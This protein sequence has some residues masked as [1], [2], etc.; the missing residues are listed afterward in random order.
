[1]K[2]RRLLSH[3]ES[4]NDRQRR[5]ASYRLGKLRDPTVVP[6]LIR[7]YSDTDPGVRLNVVD[8]LR[9]IGTPEALEFLTQIQADV[10]RTSNHR[11]VQLASV[12]RNMAW[13]LIVGGALAGLT[14]VGVSFEYSSASAYMAYAA[15]VGLGAG[16]ILRYLSETTHTIIDIE[17]HTRRSAEA[18]EKLV[19]LQAGPNGH[20]ASAEVETPK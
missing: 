13:L 11:L 18:L 5:A 12:S 16:F 10:I 3:L 17:A 20:G 6:H 14:A 2:I 15:M 7:A 9:N 1:M 4:G 19:Q 8:S